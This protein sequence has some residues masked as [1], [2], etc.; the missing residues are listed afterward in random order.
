MSKRIFNIT[1]WVL[2]VILVALL[3]MSAFMKLTLAD[4]AVAQA[5]AIGLNA[6]TY[7]L[8]GVIEIVSV[9]LFIIPR[10][11]VLGALLLIAYFGGAIVTHLQHQQPVA[12]AVV[13][14]TILWITAAL[15][16]PELWQRLRSGTYGNSAH[17]LV[18]SASNRN[19]YGK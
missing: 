15:R 5:A 2:T 4:T 3:S 9:I 12:I 1:G 10:T 18:E 19:D 17:Y 16:F 6:G 14:Q 13:I 11:G 8:I 7:R